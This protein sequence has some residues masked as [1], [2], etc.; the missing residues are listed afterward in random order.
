MNNINKE[1]DNVPIPKDIDDLCKDL[2]MVFSADHI[3]VD[4]V[5]KLLENYKSNPEDWEKFALYD[6]NTYTRNLIEK[7]NGKFNI[8]VLS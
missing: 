3:N 6:P 8:I 2:H 7:G 1:L 5:K 4:Y